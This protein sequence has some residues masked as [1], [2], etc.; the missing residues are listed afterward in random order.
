MGFYRCRCFVG[1]CDELDSIG[2]AV[3]YIDAEGAE[4]VADM[5]R[6][7]GRGGGSGGG[8]MLVRREKVGG[9][10]VKSSKVG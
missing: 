3:V 10:G 2:V 1:L 5:G 6:G 4:N 7:R 8:A 9:A